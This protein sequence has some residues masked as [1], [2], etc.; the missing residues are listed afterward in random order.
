MHGSPLKRL[1]K[2]MLAKCTSMA[3]TACFEVSKN[4]QRQAK[5]KGI[6]TVAFAWMKN[7]HAYISSFSKFASDLITSLTK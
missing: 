4:L 5:K 3:P 7:H 6:K 2:K 1:A